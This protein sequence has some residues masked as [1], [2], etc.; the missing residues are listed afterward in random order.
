MNDYLL[1]KL[2]NNRKYRVLIDKGQW[3]D[4]WIIWFEIAL[5]DRCFDRWGMAT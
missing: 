5:C 4:S 3:E 1:H 2:C